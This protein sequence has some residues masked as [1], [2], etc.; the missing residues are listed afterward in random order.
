MQKPDLNSPAMQK[1]LHSP[2]QTDSSI[3]PKNPKTHLKKKRHRISGAFKPLKKGPAAPSNDLRL[4]D[5]MD[6]SDQL[7]SET[8]QPQPGLSFTPPHFFK[9]AR[10]IKHNAVP[11]TSF[12]NLGDFALSPHPT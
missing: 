9:A 11:A 10:S 4:T 1:P 8:T 5:D 12:Q 6:T 7:E 2:T 3:P